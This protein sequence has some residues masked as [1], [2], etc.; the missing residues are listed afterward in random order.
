MQLFSVMLMSFLGLLLY[1]GLSGMWYGIEQYFKS[2]AMRRLLLM[3][4][5]W[6][7]VAGILLGIPL[8]NWLNKQIVI[9]IG[10]RFDLTAVY[11]PLSL[12]V[13]AVFV[14]TISVAT[15]LLFS[16]KLKTLDMVSG[17]KSV[18]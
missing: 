16:K 7:S 10:D 12:G 13:C 15:N 8:G 14:L 18:D 6:F 4:N 17:L 1:S 9:M 5:L 11:T 3:Q 2:S